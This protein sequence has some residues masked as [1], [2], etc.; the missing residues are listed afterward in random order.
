MAKS[1]DTYAESILQ[2]ITERTRAGDHVSDAERET[3][4]QD[5]SASQRIEG[6]EM[7]YEMVAEAVD[8]VLS[9]PLPTLK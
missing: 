5:I 1:I 8:E 4:I 2:G 6:I 3:I 7:S 9:E